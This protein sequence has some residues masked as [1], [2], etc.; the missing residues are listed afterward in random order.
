VTGGPVAWPSERRRLTSERRRRPAGCGI[1]HSKLAPEHTCS[2]QEGLG[3]SE[4]QGTCQTLLREADTDGD[5]ALDYA[6]FSAFYSKHTACAA[7]RHL[8]CTLGLKAERELA[9]AQ[10][11]AGYCV[12]VQVLPEPS[13]HTQT[14]PLPPPQACC[15]TASRALPAMERRALS[16]P[17]STRLALPSC[18]RTR[19]CWGRHLRRTMWTLCLRRLRAARSRAGAGGRRRVGGESRNQVPSALLER[20]GPRWPAGHQ[21]DAAVAKLPTN[22]L[23]CWGRRLDFDAFCVALAA[24]AERRGVPVADVVRSVVGAS[25]PADNSSAHAPP[26]FVRFHD[27]KTTFTGELRQQGQRVPALSSLSLPPL[28]A[29]THAHSPALPCPCPGAQACMRAAARQWWSHRST[30]PTSSAACRT[31]CR[32]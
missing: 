9:A 13:A 11:C 22:L 5:G 15:T 10:R 31:A 2:P 25:G 16:L 4:I 30:C 1:C 19:R 7:R 23:L 3:V 20:P 12:G 18:A 28:Y 27:D 17:S 14:R 32:H 21:F 6:E 29:C 24:V 8:R 26:E